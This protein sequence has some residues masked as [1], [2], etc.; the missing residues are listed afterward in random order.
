MFQYV[1][2]RVVL[3]HKAPTNTA[4]VKENLKQTGVMTKKYPKLAKGDKV[5]LFHKKD[6]EK[7]AN[8]HLVR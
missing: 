1:Y 3:I 4:E 2:L 8:T 5:R 7:I 6:K